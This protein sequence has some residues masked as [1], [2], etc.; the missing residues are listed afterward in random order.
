MLI[1][2]LPATRIISKYGL[3]DAVLYVDPP[4]LESTRAGRDRS[5]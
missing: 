1:E 5:R 4:Y 2:N 3:P